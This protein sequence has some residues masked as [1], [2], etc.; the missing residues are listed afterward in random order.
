ML[1][2][3]P[4]LFFAFLFAVGLAPAQDA[5]LLE[6]SIQPN[7][8]TEKPGAR[9]KKPSSPASNPAPDV[10]N[11]SQS[12]YAIVELAVQENDGA[13]PAEHFY[14]DVFKVLPDGRREMV[15]TK[16]QVGNRCQL[17]L[18][19]GYEHQLKIEIW[20]HETVELSIAPT[21][22]EAGV[23]ALKKEAILK[24]LAVPEAPPAPAPD[25]V[26]EEEEEEVPVVS[27]ALA[28][29]PV[30]ASTA[31]EPVAAPAPAPAA[32]PAQKYWR[33]STNAALHHEMDETSRAIARLSAGA[34][35]EVLERTTKEWWLASYQGKVGWLATSSLD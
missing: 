12:K 30:E 20:E 6:A 23:A 13:A 16:R 28:E 35:V 24:K 15:R 7:M 27:L 14:L 19:R 34:Q 31:N 33:L 3:K 10:D 11:T 9:R 21:E 4:G 25:L 1:M 26:I 32:K 17:Y 8:L 5:P 2:R 22:I 18:E 29:L